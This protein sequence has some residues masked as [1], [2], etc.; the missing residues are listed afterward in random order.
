M[1]S[2]GSGSGPCSPQCK[3]PRPSDGV[4]GD[5]SPGQR[6]VWAGFSPE[7]TPAQRRRI[8]AKP[9]RPGCS[10]FISSALWDSHVLLDLRGAQTRAE[11]VL[12]RESL[13][14]ARPA[15]RGGHT[16]VKLNLAS[17]LKDWAI[18]ASVAL[19]LADLQSTW[20]RE[21]AADASPRTFSFRKA[22]RRGMPA[23]C[24]SPHDRGRALGLA[25]ISWICPGGAHILLGRPTGLERNRL[26]RP[27]QRAACG[28]T[29]AGALSPH[30]ADQLTWAPALRIAVMIH[31]ISYCQQARERP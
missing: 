24:F 30:A 31:R 26:L 17:T 27:G 18:Y 20:R 1:R 29:D 28:F 15:Q 22:D 8:L 3:A 13:R 5:P 10:R 11:S 21:F 23:P 19:A 2:P 4:R 12:D 9:A 6:V 7:T 25:F 14:A 16:Y